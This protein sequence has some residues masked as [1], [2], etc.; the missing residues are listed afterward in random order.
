MATSRT[1]KVKAPADKPAAPNAALEGKVSALEAKV[2]SLEKA[3]SSLSATLNKLMADC[4]AKP[5]QSASVDLSKIN[6]KIDSLQRAVSR[7]MDKV[8]R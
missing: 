7:K 6:G 1:S 8:R 3:L 2:A 5:A 4:A